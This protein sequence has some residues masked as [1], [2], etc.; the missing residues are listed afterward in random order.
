MFVL[1]V[2]S[3]ILYF[4]FFHIT[5][6][7]SHHWLSI[8]FIHFEYVMHPYTEYEKYSFLFYSPPDR[9]LGSPR[10]SLLWAVLCYDWLSPAFLWVQGAIMHTSWKRHREAEAIGHGAC[11]VLEGEANCRFQRTAPVNTAIIRR[12]GLLFFDV[13]DYQMFWLTNQSRLRLASHFSTYWWD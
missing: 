11:S 10:L 4:D 5:I 1:H 2:I 12:W 7:R 9:H 13:W 6:V 3:W 8:L